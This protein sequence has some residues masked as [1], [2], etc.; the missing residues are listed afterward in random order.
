MITEKAMITNLGVR[1]L[2]EQDGARHPGYANVVVAG[3]ARHAAVGLHIA[4]N[5][6]IMEAAPM[7]EVLVRF[8]ELIRGSDGQEYQPQAC[9]VVGPDGLWEGW[10]EFLTPTGA[11]RTERETSQPNRADLMYWAQGLTRTYLEG[12]LTRALG[13]RVAVL[14]AEVR[15]AP[16]FEGP[17][18]PP[19]RQSTASLPHAILD[20]FAVYVQGEHV[21]RRQLLAL[22]SDQ[23]SNVIVAYALGDPIPPSS[24]GAETA[25]RVEETIAT[26]RQH[27]QIQSFAPR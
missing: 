15:V 3:V 21:L 10:I 11:V 22:S 25:R 6:T 19:T 14:P 1:G 24:S 17:A 5:Q 2:R 18:P 12:A 13:G 27:A 23:L 4:R 16:V 9:G 8:T 20:P 7:S 26:V